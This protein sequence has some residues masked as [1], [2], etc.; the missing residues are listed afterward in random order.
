MLL[1]A[2][3]ASEAVIGLLI[4]ISFNATLTQR[5]FAAK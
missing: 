3:A 1:A 4:E 5:Y 2:L